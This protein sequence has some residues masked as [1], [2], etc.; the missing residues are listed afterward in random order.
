MP[1]L[2]MLEPCPRCGTLLPYRDT[3]GNQYCPECKEWAYCGFCYRLIIKINED[4]YA[5]PYIEGSPLHFGSPSPTD[6]EANERWLR[7][8]RFKHFPFT[9]NEYRIAV[10]KF[11]KKLN[12][13]EF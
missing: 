5:C 8:E 6:E 9:L 7:D 1:V 10:K 13:V 11:K 2:E 3:S 4:G 12:R